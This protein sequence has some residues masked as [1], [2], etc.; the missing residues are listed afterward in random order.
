[1]AKGAHTGLYASCMPP[2]LLQIA[3]PSL[4]THSSRHF[5]RNSGSNACMI[6]PALTIKDFTANQGLC[7]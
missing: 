4:H 6:L 2:I 7:C 5:K 3:L 1:M